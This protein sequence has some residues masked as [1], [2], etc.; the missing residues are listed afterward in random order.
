MFTLYIYRRKT[1]CLSDFWIE[2]PALP[3]QSWLF[4]AD[5]ATLFQ[6]LALKKWTGLIFYFYCFLLDFGKKSLFWFSEGRRLTIFPYQVGGLFRNFPRFLYTL[7]LATPGPP[8][9]HLNRQHGYRVIP[10]AI[11]HR[12][13]MDVWVSGGDKKCNFATVGALCV[14][15]LT[16]SR[17]IC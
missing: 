13:L 12:F 11:V 6:R 8:E 17:Y 3:F 10:N 15:L 9:E 2:G 14:C 1:P 16:V 7:P 5:A 4:S